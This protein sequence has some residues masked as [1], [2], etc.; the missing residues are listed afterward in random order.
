MENLFGKFHLILCSQN[1][2]TQIAKFSH[3]FV[4]G[5]NLPFFPLSKQHRNSSLKTIYIQ[6][7]SCADGLHRPCGTVSVPLLGERPEQLQ[8]LQTRNFYLSHSKLP[9]AKPVHVS[10]HSLD[11]MSAMDAGN[12]GTK[13]AVALMERARYL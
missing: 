13:P 2:H 10:A 3:F 9:F 6:N 7:V 5:N 1:I 8:E 11:R 12:V 4:N